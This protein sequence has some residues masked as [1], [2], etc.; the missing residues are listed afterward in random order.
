ML[1]EI[2]AFAN[3]EIILTAGTFNTPKLLMLSG[4]GPKDHLAE[5]GI[6][7]VK[8]LPGVGQN[9]KDHP[10]VFLTALMDGRFFNR[11]AFESSP[12]LISA[13]QTQWDE[14]GTGEMSKQFSSLPVMFNKLSKI[15]DTPEF[16]ALDKQEKEYLRQDT[17]PSYEAV[18]M[19]PKF[20]PTL[21]VP[22][23]KDYLNLAVF[24]MNPQGSGTVTLSSSN[25]DDAAVIDP[26]TLS[27]PFDKMVLVEAILD[28]I[29]IFQ[30]TEI[31]KQGFHGWLNGP[32]SLQRGDVEKLIEEQ[33][34][35][36][37]HANGTVRMGR[38]EEGACV[39]GGGRVF[40][41]K[42]L[43]VADMSVSPVTIK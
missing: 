42:G 5:H 2:P 43:R 10:S 32:K 27:H 11:T 31:Y 41:V 30:E 37:W 25:P 39:D 7:L 6:P 36:V 29:R 1:N 12:S 40:G 4:I 22:T 20:P 13:A 8:H 14:S 24:A 21:E 34:L 28:A 35:L 18:F 15:Y 23:G 3:H 33:A 17:V 19:G 38:E 26:E 9:M 16:H